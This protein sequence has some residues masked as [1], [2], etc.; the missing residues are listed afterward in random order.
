MKILCNACEAAEARVYCCADEAALCWECDQK[1]HAANKLASKHQRVPLTSS[2]SSLVPK[3]DICQ[4]AL[5]YFFCLNDRA[6]L[7]RKCDVSIHS[8]NSLVSAHQRFLVT[9]VR[10]GIEPNERT[11]SVAREQEIPQPPPKLASEGSLSMSLSRG[12]HK[13]GPNQVGWNESFPVSRA[14]V[15]GGATTPSMSGWPLNEFFGADF[16]HDC[17]F[18]GNESSKANSGKLGNSED[19]SVHRCGDE[20]LELECCMDQVPD[21]RW[22]V[23]EITSPPTSSGVNWPRNPRSA[24]EASVFVPDIGGSSF[25]GAAAAKRRRPI[26][27]FPH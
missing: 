14:V 15:N 22:T 16:N 4:D 3:C 26:G 11:S 8:V 25:H 10:V 5:G 17:G 6:L 13:A 1:V 9:G 20:E 19:S 7:C 18:Q 12:E 23:P 24:A 27:D 21:M 2:S